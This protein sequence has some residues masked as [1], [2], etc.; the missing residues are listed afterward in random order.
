[1]PHAMTT[2]PVTVGSVRAEYVPGRALGIGTALPRL[3][4]ITA[5]GRDG[6]MHT[7]VMI[8]VEVPPNTSATVVRPGRGDEPLTVLAG[9][10]RWNYTVA[11]SVAAEWADPPDR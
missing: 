3:S 7:G 9:T 5:T 10:H 11:E 8:E 6:W 4:W 2:G 1:M